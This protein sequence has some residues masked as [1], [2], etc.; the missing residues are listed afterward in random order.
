MPGY[1]Y[2]SSPNCDITHHVHL[3]GHHG[4]HLTLNKTTR[5]RDFTIAH[6]VLNEGNNRDDSIK[7]K[8]CLDSS[9]NNHLKNLSSPDSDE[10][11]EVKSLNNHHSNSHL[12]SAH[13]NS[14]NQHH[15]HLLNHN[16]LRL[17][18]DSKCNN[19]TENNNRSNTNGNHSTDKLNDSL[20]SNVNQRLLGDNC[21][22]SD[23]GQSESMNEDKLNGD[24]YDDLDD[25]MD[26][27]ED[28]SDLINCSNGYF[29]KRKQRRYRTTFTSFQLEELEKSFSK[30]HYPDV[31]TRE[32]LAG[33][34][35]LTEARVQVW[36]Q[37]RRAKHRK[38]DKSPNGPGLDPNPGPVYNNIGL[39]HG[40][41]NN[42]PPTL[43]P[44]RVNMGTGPSAQNGIS[45][46][47]NGLSGQPNPTG[48]VGLN[49]LPGLSAGDTL[50]NPFLTNFFN[51]LHPETKGSSPYPSIPLTLASSPNG[52]PGFAGFP[53]AAAAAAAAGTY[54][55]LFNSRLA[56]SSFNTLLAN[57][58][59]TGA[60]NPASFQ[61]LLAT[62]SS[63]YGTNHPNLHSYPSSH[64]PSSHL[65]HHPHPHQPSQQPQ[66]QQASSCSSST[67]SSS[68][69]SHPN[70]PPS[71][72][73]SV[74]DDSPDKA[75]SPPPRKSSSPPV[76]SASTNG[77]SNES[78]HSN[79]KEP[80]QS[81]NGT[82]LCLVTKEF[83]EKKFHEKSSNETFRSSSIAVL[84]AK[85]RE[86]EITLRRETDVKE[87]DEEEDED[88]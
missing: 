39:Y 52:L 55:S 27:M 4:H 33:K 43:L 47:P 65:Q 50:N 38:Q 13:L 24:D 3:N 9:N 21:D 34:I 8:S 58:H 61:N 88:K 86:H 53:S 29:P 20:S 18:S 1:R 78:T 64:L 74:T 17:S 25:N 35:G 19:L 76:N 23:Q 6:L 72:T 37:N 40:S 69:H 12:S 30:S 48:S 22:S 56:A 63:I 62:L 5:S 67:S 87:E 68:S 36:F 42:H 85:A 14:L 73:I 10:E 77:N 31:F 32:E 7:G 75:P 26:R 79:N 83:G 28:T 59:L 80:N 81:T 45:P 15:Y 54:Q 71:P 57:S 51:H 16:Y 44:S 11:P 82:P 2:S 66:P 41:P 46:L 84:R 60:N 49:S 70:L